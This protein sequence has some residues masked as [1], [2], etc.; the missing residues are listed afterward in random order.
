MTQTIIK[1]LNQPDTVI[2]DLILSENIKQGSDDQNATLPKPKPKREHLPSLS[3]TTAIAL[4]VTPLE[5]LNLS[6]IEFKERHV[7]NL[8]GLK[9]A[10]PR[11]KQEYLRQMS[12]KFEDDVRMETTLTLDLIKRVH[13]TVAKLLQCKDQL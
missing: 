7:F 12:V 10:A 1:K 5:S 2:G 6:D 9:K 11:I 4:L 8:E 13:A 3:E